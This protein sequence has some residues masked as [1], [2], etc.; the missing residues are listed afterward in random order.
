MSHSVWSRSSVAVL[1]ETRTIFSWVFSASC[2]RR[3]VRVASLPDCSSQVSG[4]AP[5]LQLQLSSTYT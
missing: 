5:G 1:R 2:S 3:Q 4:P